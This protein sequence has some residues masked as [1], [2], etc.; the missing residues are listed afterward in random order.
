MDTA[1]HLEEHPILSIGAAADQSEDLLF[2]ELPVVG[3]WRDA[4][5]GKSTRFS[6]A[7]ADSLSI[8]LKIYHPKTLAESDCRYIGLWE[9]EENLPSCDIPWTE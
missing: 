9:D 8:L 6:C 4:Q 7:E 1:L 5:R 3:D 2:L